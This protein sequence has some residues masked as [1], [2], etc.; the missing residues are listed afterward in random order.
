MG[1]I[2]F[3]G[4]CYNLIIAVFF[5]SFLFAGC[6]KDDKITDNGNTGN[7]VTPGKYSYKLQE[8]LDGLDLWT[9]PCTQKVN[10]NDEAP[11]D[12]NSG[13]RICAAKNEFEPF[14]IILGKGSGSAKVS[15]SEFSGLGSSYEL[16]ISKVGFES[17]WAESLSDINSGDEVSLS[18]SQCTPLWFTVYVPADIQAGTKKAVLTIT[19]D[20]KTTEIPVELYVFNFALSED[21]HFA[22]QFNKSVSGESAHNELY[23]HRLTPKSATWPSG[24]SY[25]ITWPSPYNAFYDETDQSAEYGIKYLAAKYINGEGWSGSGYPNAMAFQFVDNNTPRPGTFAGISRGSSHYGTTEYNAAWK[26]YLAALNN[27]LVANGYEDEVYY[28]VMNEPQDADDYDLAA[29]LS[30]LTKEAAPDLRIAISEEPKAEIAENQT[31]GNC[32]Y[33]IWMASLQHFKRDYAAMRMKKGEEVWLYSL[34]QDPDPFFNPAK[35]ANQGIH[36]RIIPWVSWACRTRGWAYYDGGEFYDNGNPNIRMELLRE[37]FED[38]EYLY[39]ANGSKYPEAG[40]TYDIDA[41]VHSVATSLTSWTKDADAV[42]DL[43]WKLGYYIENNYT[44]EVPVLEIEA[45]RPKGEYY[46]NFQ[47][48]NGKPTINSLVVDGKTYI[49][50]GWDAYNTTNY[51]GWSGSA[52]GNAGRALS[53]YTDASNYNELEKSCIYDDYGHI[54]TF[55]FDLENGEYDVEVGVGRPNK[56]YSDAT[57]VSIE[58]V[59]FYDEERNIENCDSRTRSVTISDGTLTLTMGTIIDSKGQYTFLNYLK[60]V[61]CE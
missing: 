28:Y 58:G 17:G 6:E 59:K 49:K 4:K 41:T 25:N 12:E 9:M 57:N 21:I 30:Q 23:K 8:S 52:V 39:T 32:S 42:M 20:Q 26:K 2:H 51:Y 36:Q 34:P 18:S 14:Q 48:I 37:G 43:K 45:N 29:Y 3:N 5:L 54:N 60:I 50:V 47:D 7:N 15:I 16:V 40:Q 56:T 11:S 19:Y 61:P 33:D 35:V 27:Y 55:E 53:S 1:I 44:G 22:T 46:I 10:I 38:Y 13:I 31:Y 24:F